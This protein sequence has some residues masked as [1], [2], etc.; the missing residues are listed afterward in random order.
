MTLQRKIFDV[1]RRYRTKRNF[2]S[3]LSVFIR[4]EVLCFESDGY[5]HYD[6]VF[7]YT[8][9]S[10]TDGQTKYWLLQPDEPS[11]LWRTLF[12]PLG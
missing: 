11:D 6:N 8:F 2:M 9:L 4:G 12:E 1:G 7:G 5:S 3:G 10:E